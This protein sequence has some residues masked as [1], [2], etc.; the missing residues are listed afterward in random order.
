M[1]HSFVDTAIACAIIDRLEGVPS[2]ISV[3]MATYDDDQ[4][5]S[6]LNH[7]SQGDELIIL[8]DS[9]T[10]ETIEMIV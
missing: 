1:S 6:I 10:D 8:D 3:C 2:M 5:S 4:L 7:V 9:S